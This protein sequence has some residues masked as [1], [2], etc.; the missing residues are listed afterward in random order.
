MKDVVATLKPGTFIA[1]MTMGHAFDLPV[2]TAALERNVFPYIGVIGSDQ[3]AAVIR[4]DLKK[5]GFAQEMIDKVFCPIG[6][7]LGKNTPVEITI[8]IVAQLLKERDKS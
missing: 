1:S 5:H 6:E 7:P 4:S 3:K 2:L 8:S